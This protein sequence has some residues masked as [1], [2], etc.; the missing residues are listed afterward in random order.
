MMN[1]IDLNIK[2]ITKENIL[3]EISDWDIYKFYYPDFKLHKKT[4]SP[5]RSESNPS[6]YFFLSENTNIYWRDW[7]D[8]DQKK[9]GDCF[10]FVQKMYDC[11]FMEA[12]TKINHDMC[13]NLASEN[14]I[15]KKKSSE[16]DTAKPKIRSKITF[17]KRPFKIYDLNFWEKRYG[18]RLHQLEDYNIYAV[19]EICINEMN[20]FRSSSSNPIY[21]F[22]IED[23]CK[24]YMPYSTTNKWLFSGKV[25]FIFGLDALPEYGRH[26]FITKSLKD[27]IVLN[28]IGFEAIAPQS[29]SMFICEE[30][31]NSLLGR[32]ENIYLLYDNDEPGVKAADRIKTDFSN[33]KVISLPAL[34]SKKIK[35]ISDYMEL[36]QD[37]DDLKQ[38]L[39]KLMI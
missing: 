35:D 23:G 25:D 15:Y 21:A 20:I 30:L 9:P 34:P 11:G 22:V 5:F 26:L 17:T 3:S 29:E 18:I 27:I 37:I 31:Y 39:Q 6:C 7:G 14:H 10:S 1:I 4:L 36:Y 13:L 19:D 38:L 28:N 24:I 2:E 33:L 32:F 16:K 8:P 12:L